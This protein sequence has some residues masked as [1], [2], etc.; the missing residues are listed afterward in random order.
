MT[1][2]YDHTLMLEMT[3]HTRLRTIV[4]FHCAKT[5]NPISFYIVATDGSLMRSTKHPIKHFATSHTMTY[6]CAERM[7]AITCQSAL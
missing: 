4:S 2:A 6:R 7:N 5:R 1:V 3:C